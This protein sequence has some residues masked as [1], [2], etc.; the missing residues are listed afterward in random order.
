MKKFN[1]QQAL[2][3]K[4]V[5]TRSGKKTTDIVL[6]NK[7]VPWPIIAKVEGNTRLFDIYGRDDTKEKSANDLFMAEDYSWVIGIVV[8]LLGGTALV[9]GILLVAYSL[10]FTS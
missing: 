9:Y 4:R 1:L 8:A 2:E 10:L 5:V 6:L 3:G 7:A